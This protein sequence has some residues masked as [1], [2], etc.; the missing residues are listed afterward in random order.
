MK[1]TIALLAILL[2]LTGCA[3]T[4]ARFDSTHIEAAPDDKALVYFYRP[5]AFQGS[6]MGFHV[7]ANGAKIGILDNGA[8]FKTVLRPNTYKIHSR[9]MAIDRISTFVFEAGKTYYVRSFIE[10]GLWVSSFRFSLIHKDDAM[11]DM[12]KLRIQ[13][14][15][16]T[17]PIANSVSDSNTPLPSE[18]L[19]HSSDTNIPETPQAAPIKSS[20]QFIEAS[21]KLAQQKLINYPAPEKPL[22]PST[23]KIAPINPAMILCME[24]AK[25]SAWYSINS[26]DIRKKYQG[27]NHSKY[28]NALNKRVESTCL[29]QEV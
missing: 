24:K 23:K 9:S 29:E 1:K 5:S 25:K 7:V 21:D 11:L 18:Q 10:M 16:E 2:L 28:L 3:N 26:A 20:T 6:A 27:K 4:G 13:L 22:T 19:T 8:Y 14:D 15:N 17:S 12:R